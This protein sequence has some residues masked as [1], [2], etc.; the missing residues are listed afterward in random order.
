MWSRFMPSINRVLEIIEKCTIRKVHYI[1]AD[2]GFQ[3]TY[4]PGGRLFDLKLGGGSLLDV[5]VYPLFLTTLLLGE[6]SV[7]KS[8]GKLAATGADEYAHVIFQYP[9]G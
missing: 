9:G 1:K 6:P 4:N 3:A 8:V 7:I 5:G 2:F